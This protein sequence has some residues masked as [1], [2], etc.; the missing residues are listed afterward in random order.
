[1]FLRTIIVNLPTEVCLFVCRPIWSTNAA[2]DR[3]HTKT[4]TGSLSDRTCAME[5]GLN[6]RNTRLDSSSANGDA[7]NT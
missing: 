2:Q 6:Y 5:T 7:M 3:S 4:A 1:M